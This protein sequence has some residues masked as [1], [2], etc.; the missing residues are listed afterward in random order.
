MGHKL[1]IDQI[2]SQ[3][4]YDLSDNLYFSDRFDSVPL[5]PHSK[6]IL[7]EIHPRAAY[8]INNEPFI[9]F[10][11]E[12]LN[13]ESLFKTVS[14][15]IWNAQIPVVIF[16]DE[17]VVKIFNGTSLQ[18]STYTITQVG[19]CTAESLDENSDFSYWSISDPVFW[20]K[21]LQD[22]SA[23][24][25]NQVLL[26]NIAFL[27][28][29]LKYAYG[30]PFATKLVLRLI[31]IRYLIDRGVDLDYE[32]F[33]AEV[34]QSQAEFLKIVGNKA[35]VYKLFSHLKAKFNGNLFELDDEINCP[36]LV[37]SAFELLFAFFSGKEVF[38]RCGRQLSLFKLYDFNIIPIELISSIYEILLG[39]K[40]RD[41][42]NAFYTP[43]YLVEYVLDKTITKGLKSKNELKVLDPAC[44][45]G[46]F[47]VDSYR[48]IIQKNLGEKTYCEDDA[49]L[50]RLLTDNIFGIDIN[51]EAINVTTF[52][53]YLTILDYKDPK[54]LSEFTLPNLKGQNLFV[55]DFFDEGNLAFLLDDRI[56]F[57][58]I[59][60][61]PPWGNEKDGL[62]MA[63]CR[64]NGY[65]DMQQNN[66][67]G[68]SFVFRARDFCCEK[69]VCCFVLH[70]K[71]LYNQKGPA[72]KF[73]KWLLEK[74]EICEIVELSSVRDL[75]FENAKA[76]A[77][78]VAFKYNNQ[79]NLNNEFLYTSI[80]P[81]IFFKLFHIICIEKK[82]MKYVPQLLLY[83]YDW[84]WKVIVYGYSR[85]LENILKLKGRYQTL[86]D[87]ISGQ[88]PEIIMGAGVECQDG[89]R[90]D[91][92]HL[93][94]RKLLDS[95]KGVD[96][97]IV[98][99]S[100]ASRFDKPQIH[101]PRD[102]RLFEP[103]Y[104][105]TPTGIDCSNYKL[106]AAYSEEAFVA[107]KT[108]YIIKGAFE[109]KQFLM[110]VVGLL[111]SSLYAYFNLMLG[112]SVGVEREQRSMNAILSYPYMFSGEIAEKVN[113]I[114]MAIA[115]KYSKIFYNHDIENDVKQLDELVLTT[116]QLEN[117]NFVDYAINIQIPELTNS[118]SCQGHRKVGV[119]DL[120]EYSKCFIKYFSAIYGHGDY[121][122][123][124]TLYP[125]V[126]VN[127]AVFELQIVA[128]RGES[129]VTVANAADDEKTFLTKFAA[130]AHNDRFY[131]IRD[132]VHFGTDSFFIIKPNIYKNWHPAMA[133][134]DLAD[135]IEDIMSAF[136]GNR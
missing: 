9:L 90:K 5:M 84:A 61:N 73:R 1:P 123:F 136:G 132:I 98:N 133:E 13:D 131:Q 48:R 39:E 32:G 23:T 71:L 58:Y 81:N 93:L 87:A 91:A 82:D 105:L 7:E 62:H 78:I 64:E 118:D 120:K 57:D 79:N 60:G 130:Y 97:F 40:T 16:C 31:F 135:V 115:Q 104:V 2:I 83:N 11:D 69:T 94:G 66:D 47:L 44:G 51:E 108:M 21:Y 12:N 116:F 109:Q 86:G 8:I 55:S 67:V 41:R 6:R 111:N 122:I 22:Y 68:R 49:K 27:T 17:S 42:D 125:A 53:L 113:H 3:L 76:P 4:G 28:D 24:K 45:S 63:Y 30:I 110:C 46:V 114:Q 56:E 99:S 36:E 100:G 65:A 10:F 134:L 121:H 54:S 25:L 127:Y 119:E 117:D 89:D 85:D 59:I 77:A 128:G 96:H 52:S 35:E 26:N 70:A 92:T 101:R 88:V 74:S 19:L 34:S 102:R 29:E 75:V 37:E 95:Q 38:G 50:K 15:Q 106:R 112:S 124:A 107:K 129:E 20:S 80:K 72:V 103:P 14:R 18:L 43:N 126:G 33:T